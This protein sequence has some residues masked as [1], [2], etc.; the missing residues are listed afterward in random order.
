[1]ASEAAALGAPEGKRLL[2]VL[3]A[4]GGAAGIVGV[5]SWWAQ[6]RLLAVDPAFAE[7]IVTFQ[8]YGVLVGSL[9]LGFRPSQAPPLSLR[10]AK[11]VFFA[12]APVALAGAIAVSAIIYA[13]LSPFVGSVE[14]SVRGVLS[15]ATDVKWIGIAPLQ[16]WAIATLRGTLL[17]P[18]FE[19]LLFRGAVLGWLAKRLPLSW[20]IV[21]SA[22]L[23]ALMHGFPIVMPYAF[24]FGLIAGWL[25]VR[26]GSTLPGLLMHA[27][28]NLLF[29]AAALLIL[30]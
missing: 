26:S 29:L 23:F 13:L 12:I 9:I 14:Q 28:N 17:A 18:L 5:V 3:A 27:L 1:V 11:P 16:V 19:E 8:V 15:I 22:T 7:Q 4:A 10:R 21:V 6:S 25:R 20:A 24:L 30:K 2:L